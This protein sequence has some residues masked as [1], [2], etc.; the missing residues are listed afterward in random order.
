MVE[1]KQSALNDIYW[2]RARNLANKN[3]KDWSDCYENGGKLRDLPIITNRHVFQ[4]FLYE[5]SVFRGFGREEMDRVFPRLKSIPEP[6]GDDFRG[7]LKFVKECFKE[8]GK[9]RSVI[10]F[11][12][13]LLA[14]WKPAVF[15]MWDQ[16]VRIGLRKLVV[17][18]H[19]CGFY[20]HEIQSYENFRSIF[21]ETCN[22][23][24]RHS[25]D[26]GILTTDRQDSGFTN[27][28]LD[29]ALVELGKQN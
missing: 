27:R 19:G 6:E 12:S 2:K 29:I 13:K 20:A 9:T 11:T 7:P 10:S 25:K 8:V 26:I 23:L 18:P 15:P 17:V 4:S 5:Y 24:T 28:V 1:L 22:K 3:W 16:Y 21:L 14:H